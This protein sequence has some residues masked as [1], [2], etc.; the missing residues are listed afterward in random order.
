MDE[1]GKWKRDQRHGPQMAPARV[2]SLTVG[3][4]RCC[5]RAGIPN[6]VLQRQAERERIA[7][8]RAGKA[9]ITAAL[10]HTVDHNIVGYG[11]LQ[12][13]GYRHGTRQVH[14][15]ITEEGLDSSGATERRVTL[16]GQADD[17]YAAIAE[18]IECIRACSAFP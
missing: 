5:V 7:V 1:F 17:G 12:G 9:P 2:S 3:A 16:T 13:S 18:I 14:E 6:G 10:K 8:Q 11:A 4:D 15:Y